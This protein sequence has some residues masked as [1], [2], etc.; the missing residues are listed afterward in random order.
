[1]D[2]CGRQSAQYCADRGRL[3]HNIKYSY[4]RYSDILQFATYRMNGQT[5]LNNWAASGGHKAQLNC[6]TVT[7]AGVGVVYKNGTY[8]M[9]IVYDWSGTN[10]G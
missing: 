7:K 8:Y 10:V 5:A 9:S 1:M 6:R 2:G 4:D 3:E